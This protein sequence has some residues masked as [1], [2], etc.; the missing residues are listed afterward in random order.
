MRGELALVAAQGGGVHGPSPH[1]RGTLIELHEGAVRKRSIPACAGNTV[2]T[3]RPR[4]SRAVHPR[5][6]GEHV[7]ASLRSG[8]KYGPS[9][10]ARGTRPY[11]AAASLPARS[12]PACAGNTPRPEAGASRPTVHPRMRGEHVAE[13]GATNEG[14]GPSPHARGTRVDRSA[15][16]DGVRSIPACAGNTCPRHAWRCTQPVHPR[17]RGEHAATEPKGWPEVGPSPHARGT[18]RRY[19]HRPRRMRSIPACAGNTDDAMVERACR[20]V[21][22]RMRGEHGDRLRLR[23]LGGGPSPHARGTRCGGAVG[24]LPRR[25]IP[26]CAGNT[27]AWSIR[28]WWRA[29]HPRMRGE[30]LILKD[31]KTG[32]DGPSPHARGTPG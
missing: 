5:M 15:G 8:S 21:H 18:R 22:P 26:A 20:A 12:I 7:M 4:A 10:H 1:A 17:M 11:H 31:K 2:C 14:R 30:H 32:G 27:A 19:G 16:R 24:G 3:A 9:P 28:R 13:G 25:S 23:D 29:V 6:R